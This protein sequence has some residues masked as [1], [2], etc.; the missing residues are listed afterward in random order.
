MDLS[1]DFILG[2][3]G[4]IIALLTLYLTYRQYKISSEYR[5]DK[6]I[7][8][9]KEIYV[10]FDKKITKAIFSE[11]VNPCDLLGDGSEIF[12]SIWATKPMHIR[13]K[14]V[15]AYNELYNIL[16][17]TNS[18]DNNYIANLTILREKFAEEI[19]EILK[20]EEYEKRGTNLYLD[21]WIIIKHL[22]L[23]LFYKTK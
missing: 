5:R 2:I 23:Y 6:E 17:T 16:L 11:K 1:K 18:S 14:I 21:I 15:N 12:S 19:R 7:Q 8:D 9:F 10:I 3:F 13:E 22:F 20:I 4:A